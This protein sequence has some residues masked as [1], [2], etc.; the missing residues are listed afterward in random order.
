M[1]ILLNISILLLVLIIIL[2]IGDYFIGD[3]SF[4]QD[5]IRGTI[6]ETIGI[7][8]TI[9]LIEFIIGKNRVSENLEN[10]K[11]KLIRTNNIINIYLNN[12]NE[13][14]FYLSYTELDLKD[15]E[16]FHIE[17]SFPF[18]NL[19]ELFSFSR[20]GFYD[21]RET[22]IGVYFDRLE[23]LKEVIKTT[24][25]Q[26]DLTSFPE[27]SQLL[28]K[29]LVE[30]ESYNPKNSIQ[31]DYISNIGNVKMEKMS[32]YIKR[33]IANFEGKVEYSSENFMLNKYIRVYE[34]IKYHINF[35]KE[36]KRLIIKYIG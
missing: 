10:E 3:E 26:T 18:V 21:M 24:L 11:K 22:K 1:K 20:S 16:K 23:I 14:A 34:L 5:Y 32:E 7:I 4:V 2:G 6:T 15:K 25:Y 29:Y 28:E 30:V 33:E 31:C 9:I 35:N 12:Y 36:Y 13:S 8:L 17:E 27:L 19:S